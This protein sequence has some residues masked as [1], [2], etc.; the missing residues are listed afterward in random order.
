MQ[1][2][3]RR[4]EPGGGQGRLLRSNCVLPSGKFSS[5]QV[6]R[7]LRF[8][9]ALLLCAQSAPSA[10][11]LPLR[12]GYLCVHL[13]DST[14]VQTRGLHAW[15]SGSHYLCCPLQKRLR[16]R[17]GKKMQGDTGKRGGGGICTFDWTNLAL[18]SRLVSPPPFLRLL[19]P[20]STEKKRSNSHTR[21][22]PP[23]PRIMSII[24][25]SQK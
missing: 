25:N 18:T 11:N 17:T 9:H 24:K 14:S 8:G 12:T 16:A 23:A 3:L 4:E 6:E 1:T 7:S 22:M 13:R 21:S 20:L 15:W 19:L 5:H 2:G 10:S